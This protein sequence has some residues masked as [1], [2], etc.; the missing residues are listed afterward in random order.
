MVRLGSFSR[1]KRPLET[2]EID[3]AGEGVAKPFAVL[4]L[5]L[6]HERFF[7]LSPIIR[8]TVAEAKTA[9]R[10]HNPRL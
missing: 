1:S 10:E 2:Q 6:T 8:E 9:I 7:Q 5:E 4:W 3:K